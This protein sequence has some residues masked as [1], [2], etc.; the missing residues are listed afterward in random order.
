MSNWAADYLR[1]KELEAQLE[2]C[3]NKNKNLQDHI[4]YMCEF[5]A[6]YHEM[7]TER[8][9]VCEFKSQRYKDKESYEQY[10]E[11]QKMWSA[12]KYLLDGCK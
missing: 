1:E 7:F 3:R 12:L 8:L 11:L 6:R 5:R 2:F 10:A 9:K 4:K